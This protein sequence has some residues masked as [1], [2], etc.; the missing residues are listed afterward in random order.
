ML[1]GLVEQL[2]TGR[3]QSRL[4][5]GAYPFRDNHCRR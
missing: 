1:R 4:E 2:Q 3:L 5:L